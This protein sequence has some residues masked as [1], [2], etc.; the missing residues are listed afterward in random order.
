MG[1]GRSGAFPGTKGSDD[2]QETFFP[3]PIATRRRGKRY[4]FGD[5]PSG[6]VIGGISE[7]S[8]APAGGT[9][10]SKRRKILIRPKDV[11][12]QCQRY[13]FGSLSGPKLLGW[14]QQVLDPLTYE[15]QPPALRTLIQSR[16]AILQRAQKD[17]GSYDSRQ[18]CSSVLDFEANV[19]RLLT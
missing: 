4:A 7:G 16:I 2:Y 15:I 13:R 9:G 5:G 3:E 17:S 19:E 12:E 11:L 14:L 6:G 1:G 10:T 18:F 8:S